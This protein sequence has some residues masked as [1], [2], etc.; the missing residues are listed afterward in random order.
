MRPFKWKLLRSSFMWYCLLCCG[1]C[2]IFDHSQMNDVSV[3]EHFSNIFFILWNKLSLRKRFWLYKCMWWDSPQRKTTLLLFF[4][5]FICL[6]CSLGGHNNPLHL[7][8]DSSLDHKTEPFQFIAW[9]YRQDYWHIT[10]AVIRAATQLC[11][12]RTDRSVL[13]RPGRGTNNEWTS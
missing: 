4:F 7:L 1:R 8:G 9:S 10:N 11:D 2:Q 12:C 6:F 13:Q 3:F 5:P